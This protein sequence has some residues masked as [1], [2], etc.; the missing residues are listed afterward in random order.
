MR[1]RRVDPKTIMVPEERVTAR[2]DEEK[3]A[4]FD[5]DAGVL[6]VEFQRLAQRSLARPP[7]AAADFLKIKRRPVIR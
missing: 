5:A 2:M 7:F 3:S 4:Q 6:G 1:L